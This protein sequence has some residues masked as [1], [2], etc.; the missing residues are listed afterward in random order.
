MLKSRPVPVLFCLVCLLLFGCGGGTEIEVTLNAGDMT[1]VEISARV[2]ED[3]MAEKDNT[4][5][6]SPP[7]ARG[8]APA[9]WIGSEKRAVLFGGMSPITGDTWELDVNRRRWTELTDTLSGSPLPRCH[10]TFISDLSNANM[11]LFGGFSRQQRFN[12]L[13]RYDL[14]TRQWQED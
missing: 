13:W 4:L 3:P 11:L 2:P 9:V 8:G 1:S 5:S 14:G 10:H 12:D 6:G 7:P